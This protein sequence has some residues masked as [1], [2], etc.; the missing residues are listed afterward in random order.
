MTKLQKQI[1][2][3]VATPGLP[4]ALTASEAVH[5]PVVLS[6]AFLALFFQQWAGILIIKQF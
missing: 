4:R 1:I 5:I 6:F 2:C 3:S